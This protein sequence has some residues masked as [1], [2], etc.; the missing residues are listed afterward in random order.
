MLS[1]Y[2][3]SYEI[4]KFLIE[5]N[6]KILEFSKDGYFPILLCFCLLDEENYKIENLYLCLKF[7]D[8]LLSRQANINLPINLNGDSIL[9]KYI[10][11][12]IDNEEELT[13]VLIVLKFI[14]ERGA[15]VCYLNNNN[16]N[17]FDILEKATSNNKYYNAS[18]CKNDIDF[19]LKNTKHSYYKITSEPCLSHVPTNSILDISI[20]DSNS[21]NDNSFYSNLTHINS[22]KFILKNENSIEEVSEIKKDEC[23]IIM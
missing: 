4:A 21:I 19:I 7:I 16:E 18:K 6:A 2:K 5:R 17:A 13:R 3:G 9:Q 14:V 23:C 12:K 10:S 22:S 15:K 20:V 11:Q 1:I 8:L